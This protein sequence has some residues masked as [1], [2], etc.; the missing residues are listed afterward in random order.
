[1]ADFNISF[2]TEEFNQTLG[3]NSNK[4]NYPGPSLL[5]ASIL[6]PAASLSLTEA[7]T[8]ASEV[9]FIFSVY[10]TA[11][12]FPLANVSDIAFIASLVVGATIVGG[13]KNNLTGPV[14]LNFTVPFKVNVSTFPKTI[15]SF[16][17]DHV[18]LTR[19]FMTTP[20]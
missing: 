12:L 13:I 3:E 1:M 20:V 5:T 16:I 14:W 10:K 7:D 17:T 6:L 8:N 19:T 2:S 18:W 9:G 11:I 4:F 15:V